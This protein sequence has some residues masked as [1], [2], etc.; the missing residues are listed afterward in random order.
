MGKNILNWEDWVEV[1]DDLQLDNIREKRTHKSKN[2]DA[3]EWVKIEKELI[4]SGKKKYVK[5]KR[6]KSHQINKKNPN[7]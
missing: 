5:N 7:R 4:K 2:H 6:R 1:E 3:D